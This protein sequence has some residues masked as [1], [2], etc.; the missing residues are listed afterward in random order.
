MQLSE[1][2][3]LWPEFETFS[4]PALEKLLMQCAEFW[5]E[6]RSAPLGNAYLL[7]LIGTS[8]TGKTFL[9]EKL[10]QSA[11]V[12]VELLKHKWLVNPVRKGRWMD[13]LDQ[14]LE[15]DH[16]VID[17]LAAANFLLLD[18]IS[19]PKNRDGNVSDWAVER[20]TQLISRRMGKW[21]VL[22]AN[23]AANEIEKVDKRIVSRMIRDGNRLVKVETIDYWLRPGAK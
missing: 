22:T 7:S 5:Q 8:G 11:R 14:V 10:Y 4:D 1:A 12:N 16:A 17:E 19:F 13:I 9:G 21:T 15:R 3:K 23:V 18:E 6:M 20:L 2:K